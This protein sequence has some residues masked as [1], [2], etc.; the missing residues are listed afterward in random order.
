MSRK[1]LGLFIG[2]LTAIIGLTLLKQVLEGSPLLILLTSSVV[3]I[4]AA[5]V[6]AGAVSRKRNHFLKDDELLLKSKL[7]DDKT[8]IKLNNALYKISQ[9]G[10]LKMPIFSVFSSDR[11]AAYSYQLSPG[12]SYI[13]FSDSLIK[14]FCHRSLIGILA[15][16]ASH[17]KSRDS[18]KSVLRFITS[19]FLLNVGFFFFKHAPLYILPLIIWAELVQQREKELEADLNAAKLTALDNILHSLIDNYLLQI[20]HRESLKLKI[21]WYLPSTWAEYLQFETTVVAFKFLGTHPDWEARIKGLL[22]YHHIKLNDN[23]WDL[24]IKKALVFRIQNGFERAIDWN[25]LGLIAGKI[26]HRP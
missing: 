14:Q 21:K 2:L 25:K 15:H 20:I 12:K 4:A 9:K 18:W 3:S 1:T 6:A 16:E 8:K 7:V 23:E 22:E 10:N 5:L 19:V 17:I 24:F 13:K 26:T 11:R